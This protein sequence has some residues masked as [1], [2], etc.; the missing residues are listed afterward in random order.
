MSLRQP[1]QQGATL[2][3]SL[4]MLIVITLLAVYAIRSG[5]TNLRIAGNMQYQAEGAGAAQQAI[6]KMVEQFKSSA[7]VSLIPAQTMTLP[8]AGVNY[9]VAVAAPTCKMEVPILNSDLDVS[10]AEDIPCYESTDR[11]R[12]ILADGTLAPVPSACKQQT[13]EVTADVNDGG[14]GARLTQ[15]QGLSMRVS[16]VV[17]C[18]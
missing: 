5:N 8:M 13:W 10:K 2:V 16:V 14:T 1:R 7:N 9:S 6:E 4:I 12:P 3:I 11:D 15:V 18:P 17:P